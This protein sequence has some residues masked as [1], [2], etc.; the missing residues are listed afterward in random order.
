[1]LEIIQDKKLLEKLGANSLNM[2]K[3]SA[4]AQIV[5]EVYKLIGKDIN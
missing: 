3:P 1:M 2:S 4:T 5:D